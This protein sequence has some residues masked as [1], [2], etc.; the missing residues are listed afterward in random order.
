MQE[1]SSTALLLGCLLLNSCGTN[2]SG[3]VRCKTTTIECRQTPAADK[4]PIYR[5][6]Q[7]HWVGILQKSYKA[8]S[9]PFFNILGCEQ[10]YVL[11]LGAMNQFKATGYKQLFVKLPAGCSLPPSNTELVQILKKSPKTMDAH[12]FMA[13]APRQ[14]SAANNRML[15]QSLA[16][17]QLVLCA[18]PAKQGELS[19]K[20]PQQAAVPRQPG[21]VEFYTQKSLPLPLKAVLTPALFTVDMATTAACSTASMAG[22]AV[23]GLVTYPFYYIADSFSAK[24][25]RAKPA[26][27]AA[28]TAPKTST[29]LDSKNNATPAGKQKR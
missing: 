27:D 14:V 13:M 15:T 22:F 26:K 24:K 16:D 20:F 5:L 25:S 19:W 18:L 12:K 9:K 6:G 1:K 21:G 4:M 28:Q 29:A 2:F 11:H 8:Y 7:D 23:V 17:D 10:P 3:Y